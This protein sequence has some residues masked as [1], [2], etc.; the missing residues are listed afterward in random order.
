MTKEA[1][2]RVTNIEVEMCSSKGRSIQEII[3]ASNGSA[4]KLQL[5]STM[6]ARRITPEGSIVLYKQVIALP[7][8]LK[9]KM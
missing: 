7:L 6:R 4:H 5:S 1:R 9:R 2:F 8:M 3:V